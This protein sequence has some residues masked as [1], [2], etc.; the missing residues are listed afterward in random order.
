MDKFT[1]LSMLEIKALAF[2]LQLY[3]SSSTIRKRK[4]NL[5]ARENDTSCRSTWVFVLT[6][7]LT[8]FPS[9]R[10]RTEYLFYNS[11]KRVTVTTLDPQKVPLLCETLS[12]TIIA[13]Y[14]NHS[15]QVTRHRMFGNI[16]SASLP[17]CSHR[18]LRNDGLLTYGT[19]IIETS[20]LPKAMRMNRM[21]TW[22]ILGRLA[23]GEHIF[24]TDWAVVFV[25]VFETPVGFEDVDRNTHAALRAVSEV[26][27]SSNSTKATLVTVKRLF[28]LTHPKIA[29]ATMILSKDN[30]TVDA[31]I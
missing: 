30:F 21:T 25:L 29:F 17:C 10:P 27:L 1:S 8:V 22:Q 31:L 5:I 16:S 14:V 11:I 20:Q 2:A 28:G 12:L 4:F 3:C 7:C 18:L 9:W 23:G 24:S 19:S 26:L 15:L 13:H 6:I